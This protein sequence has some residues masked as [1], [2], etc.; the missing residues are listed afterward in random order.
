ML[1]RQ[2]IA[3]IPTAISELFKNAHDAYAENVEADFFRTRRLFVVRDD[4]LGMS[5][6][7][8]VNNWL[9]LAT[10][11]KID[12]TE[13]ESSQQVPLGRRRRATLG[14]KGI[15]R[16][17]IASIGPQVLVLT[18]SA[19]DNVDTGVVAAFI[20]WDLFALP[21]L[22]L[23]EIKVPIRIFE[24]NETPTQSDIDELV[25]SVKESLK[26]FRGR[27]DVK[28]LANIHDNLNQFKIDEDELSTIVAPNLSRRGKHGTQ[29]WIQPTDDALTLDLDDSN[30]DVYS[31]QLVRMLIGFSNT[32][33][34]GFEKP[35]ISTKFR[36]HQT[37]GIVEDL[38]DENN[39][40]TADE[41]ETA[42]HHLRGR[43]DEFGQFE[44][45]IKVYGHEPVH[46]ILPWRSARGRKTQCGPFVL[47]VAVV[48]G[49]HRNSLLPPEDWARI[50]NK[51]NLI[52]GLY[53]YKD[54][55][56]VLPYGNTDYD[57]LDIERNRTKSASYYFFSFR[58]MFGS[59]EIDQNSNTELV[60]KAGREGFR[61][62]RAY[63]E[64]RSIL[65]NFFV[66][67]AAD[68]FRSGGIHTLIFEEQKTGLERLER[69]K[70][71]RQQQVSV[72]RR[73]LQ[74]Q[75]EDFFG[76]VDDGDPQN[77]VAEVL[78]S[79]RK[80]LDGFSEDGDVN[81]YST[82]LVA[83]E[84]RARNDLR[85][86][87][88]R[89]HVVRP[90]GVG[91]SKEMRR[92][93]DN[94][95]RQ[96]IEIEQKAFDPAVREIDEIVRRHAVEAKLLIDQRRRLEA[97]IDEN[98]QNARQRTRRET[99]ETREVGKGVS[100]QIVE[101]TR[102]VM[103]DVEDT[104]RQVLAEVARTD[105]TERQESEIVE[106]RATFEEQLDQATM[107]AL[108]V[109]SSAKAQLQGIR[110]DRGS[111]GNIV[112]QLDVLEAT[113]SELLDARDRAE[114]DFEMAQL[115]AAI[116][117]I[118]HEFDASIR[119]VRSSLRRLQAW[120][121]VNPSLQ[122]LHNDIRTSFEHLDGYLTL[123]TPLQRR[124]Y[125]REVEILGSDIVSF[126]SDL[127]SERLKRHEVGLDSTKNFD[128]YKIVS[129]PSTFYPVFVNL[130]DNSLFWLSDQTQPRRI[131]LDSIG[132]AIVVSDTGPGIP[133]RDW[134]SVFELGFTRK[135]SGRGLGLYIAREALRRVGYTI[136]IRRASP[137]QGACF[138]IRRSKEG[139]K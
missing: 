29:F 25:N 55:I 30:G 68:F 51:M 39:F 128:R 26:L 37:S 19:R 92:D 62:N 107:K 9:T 117:V 96:L 67:I 80:Q 23:D 61:E 49:E 18:R 139:E 3:G 12:S 85:S 136:E 46:H 84:L 31:T 124:L 73:E 54:G 88:S 5:Y 60:E 110:W 35:V 34:P 103:T 95:R 27:I 17:A 97:A 119:R 122:G 43:F 131:L 50:I 86:I 6:E 58:R 45:T 40:F 82:E 127:F 99:S 74:Q 90:R 59:V 47:N 83:A 52:G 33:T 63:R 87:K 22:D 79:L 71:R 109:L 14:E 11:A 129:Y 13:D 105:L 42:D 53:I 1:G 89:L 7:E 48:Q 115:G 120:A 121:D 70:R 38:I 75:L 28:L 66:Q 108:D 8:I 114:I 20:N 98:V 126:L 137:L 72:R 64:F 4:G 32:M 123:F 57:F 10:D 2:Q 81:R 78:Q 134:Q 41:F 100:D 111:N 76:R 77:Q 133:E 94:Y 135:P 36:H 93:W 130:I 16:L 91:L 44:G 69:I 125:R 65:M 101:L 24:P 102:Q 116:H 56:R 104:I 112:T 138:H 106:V 15:G 21:G 118:N 113:E 132:G